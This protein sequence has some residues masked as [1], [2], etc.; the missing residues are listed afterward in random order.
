MSP[1]GTAR[2]RA[3]L[4]GRLAA[5]PARAAVAAAA[6]DGH[7]VPDG[8][9]SAGEILRHLIAVDDQVFGRRLRDLREQ[10]QPRWSWVEPRFDDGPADRP[11]SVLIDT[12]TT[13]RR[14]L[15]ASVTALTP[16]DWARSGTHATMGVLDVA[17]LLR[18]AIDHDDEHLASIDRLAAQG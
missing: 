15:V 7:L 3:E 4:V 14:A 8:E 6:A 2:Q 9:W 16:A 13:R 5:A 1:V 10:D 11:L 12:W 18:V 17:A